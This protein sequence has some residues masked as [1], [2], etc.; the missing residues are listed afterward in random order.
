MSVPPPPK[1]PAAAPV[2]APALAKKPGPPPTPAN[3]VVATPPVAVAAGVKRPA[4]APPRSGPAPA[5]QRAAVAPPAP[6]KDHS[7][8][9]LAALEASIPKVDAPTGY[10]VAMG[11]LALCLVLLPV[12]Y[13][14]L[15]GFLSWLVVWHVFQTFVSIQHGP[16]FVFHLPM[17]L[18]AGLLLLFLIK[19]VFFRDKTKDESIITLRREDEPLLFAF[20]ERLCKATGA[21]VPSRI[22]VD[23]DPNAAAGLGRG[24]L[25]LFGGDL[26]L[27]V[28]L[29]LAAGLTVRQFAGVVAHEFGHF[30]QS[31]GM[32]GSYLVRRLNGFFA[33]VVFQRDRLDEWLV[34]LR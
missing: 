29:P 32:S 25:S 15:L 16:F 8:Q 19:P 33:L 2:V 17:S 18:L 6:P 5:P 14:A 10:R 21:P 1:R 13:L 22:E 3:R 34:K 30:N 9:I 27:R 4:P 7:K 12:L 31:G 11:A 26:V 20:V 28:G 24:M 23:C